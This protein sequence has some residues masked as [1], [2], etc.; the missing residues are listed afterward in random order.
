MDD[1]ELN[2]PI[3][4]NSSNAGGDEQHSTRAGNQNFWRT[5]PSTT[6]GEVGCGHDYCHDDEKVC[7]GANGDFCDYHQLDHHSPSAVAY[8]ADAADELGRCDVGNAAQLDG[9]DGV[10]QDG[11]DHCLSVPSDACTSCASNASADDGQ[12][13]LPPKGAPFQVAERQCLCPLLLLSSLQVPVPAS[14]L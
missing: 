3:C 1:I 13:V 7:T 8:A 9:G 4:L 5:M 14:R 6:C 2:E 11:G 10:R 12:R